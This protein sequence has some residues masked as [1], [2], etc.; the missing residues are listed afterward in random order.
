MSMSTGSARAA[1]SAA[2]PVSPMKRASDA[3]PPTVVVIRLVRSKG[4]DFAQAIAQNKKSGPQG[5]TL[6]VEM[7]MSAWI[8]CTKCPLGKRF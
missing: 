1:T 7:I 8:L 4:F 5:P 6:R 2:K 3:A